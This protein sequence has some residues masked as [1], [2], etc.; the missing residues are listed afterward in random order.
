MFLRKAAS[1]IAVILLSASTIH[2][3]ANENYDG[4]KPEIYAGAKSLVFLYIPF[5]S[6]LG[7][8]PSGR[9]NLFDL[10]YYSDGYS[11]QFYDVQLGG[12][13]FKYFVTDQISLTGSFCF[14]SNTN[15]WEDTFE[16]SG[17]WG[18]HDQ[19]YT[20]EITM[21]VFGF[22]LDADYHL[23]HLYNISP[24]LGLNIN[25]ASASAEGSYTDDVDDPPFERKLDFSG[26]SFGI[27]FNIGF[28]WFFTEGLSLGGKYMLGY[29]GF[30]GPE[31]EITTKEGSYTTSSK[32]EGKTLSFVGTGIISV[33]LSVYF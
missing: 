14:G 26:S 11:V 29:Q 31:F 1:F 24:Y 20:D 28:E 16:S 17:T 32:S 9:A 8:A 12:V 25:Y 22:S 33:L 2:S 18:S 21:T 23:R 7:P 27:G 30:S 6:D 3:Q 13:G 19:T 4:P 15:D 5:Q 10:T